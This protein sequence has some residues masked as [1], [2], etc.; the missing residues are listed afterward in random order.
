MVKNKS[1]NY[2]KIDL[3]DSVESYLSVLDNCECLAPSFELFELLELYAELYEKDRFISSYIVGYHLGN[4]AFALKNSRLEKLADR[5]KRISLQN[6]HIDT[7]TLSQQIDMLWLL[8][9][10]RN[11]YASFINTLEVE[12]MQES[13]MKYFDKKILQKIG[14]VDFIAGYESGIARF[15]LYWAYSSSCKIISQ[16]FL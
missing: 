2:S 1:S 5:N 4:I 13:G 12:L 8:Q 9:K 15:L 14:D 3:L 7:M 10:E 16:S 11:K 6:M